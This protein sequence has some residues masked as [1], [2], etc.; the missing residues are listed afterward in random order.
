MRVA[1]NA[2]EIKHVS[3]VMSEWHRRAREAYFADTD[4]QEQQRVD[5]EMRMQ[6]AD[7]EFETEAE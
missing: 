2:Q 7:R 4:A 6:A 1:N 5:L 3:N